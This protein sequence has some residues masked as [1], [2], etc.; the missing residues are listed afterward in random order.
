MGLLKLFE[1]DY[2]WVHYKWY[3]EFIIEFVFPAS[4]HL[5]YLADNSS[6]AEH[7]LNI[8]SVI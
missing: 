4:M 8:Q 2:N 6:T 1:L 7:W 3:I 5:A